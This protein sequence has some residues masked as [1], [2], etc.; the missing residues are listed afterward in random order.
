MNIYITVLDKDTKR[1]NLQ[2]GSQSGKLEDW[3]LGTKSRLKSYKKNL[4]C[5]KFT[6]M[7]TVRNFEIISDIEMWN[8]NTHIMATFASTNSKRTSFGLRGHI[9]STNIFPIHLCLLCTYQTNITIIL[10][11]ATQRNCGYETE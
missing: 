4:L 5:V 6:N 3:K 8:E 9:I 10:V 1:V 2:H 7:A 11:V